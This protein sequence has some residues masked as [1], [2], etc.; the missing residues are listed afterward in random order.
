MRETTGE[1]GFAF[2]VAER[3]KARGADAPTLYREGADSADA[4]SLARP[5][6]AL[7]AA[8][9]WRRNGFASNSRSSGEH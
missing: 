5:R 7:A 9:V 4:H 2:K 8:L 1:A 6:S 3:L